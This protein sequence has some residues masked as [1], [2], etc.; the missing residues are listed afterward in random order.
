MYWPPPAYGTLG[1]RARFD[2]VD[3]SNLPASDHPRSEVTSAGRPQIGPGLGARDQPVRHREPPRR[4]PRTPQRVMD[5]FARV[6]PHHATA[7]TTSPRSYLVNDACVLLCA[8]RT[9]GGRSTASTARPACSGPIRPVLPLP[10]PR[11]AAARHG[12]LA[13]PRAVSSVCCARRSAPIQV[14]EAIKLITGIGEPLVGS[15]HG[16]RR[17]GVRYRQITRA[18]RTQNCAVCGEHPT[19]TELID[20]EEFCGVVSEGRRGGPPVRIDHHRVRN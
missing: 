11:A 18:A 5:L 2:V 14:T 20:Y 3:E 10:V 9:C 6:R 13:A 15:A 7:P 19:V 16:V 4:T 1:H 8:S 17:A 12:A